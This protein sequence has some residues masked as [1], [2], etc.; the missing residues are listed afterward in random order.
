VPLLVAA[1]QHVE[2][3][4]LGP[5]HAALE[6]HAAGQPAVEHAV[7]NPGAALDRGVTH[8]RQTAAG[9]ALA[10]NLVGHAQL[11]GDET[12]QAAAGGVGVARLPLAVDALELGLAV[13]AG[14]DLRNDVPDDLNASLA[15]VG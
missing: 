6:V 8:A 7:M 13:G 14:H 5:V 1:A 12:R 2:V 4:R 9:D 3:A 15:V 11:A 10:P